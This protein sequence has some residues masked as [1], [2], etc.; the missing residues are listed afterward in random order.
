MVMRCGDA[1]D[2]AENLIY[3]L[4]SEDYKFETITGT[5]I[6]QAIVGGQIEVTNMAVTEKGLASTNGALKNYT[7]IDKMGNMVNSPKAVI[8]N[9]VENDKGLI[10]YTMYTAVG[11][12]ADVNVET[13]VDMANRG[14][15]A[16]GKIRHTSQ[17][18][19]VA[20]IGGMYPLRVIE[21]NKAKE[22]KV[23]VGIMFIGSALSGKGVIKYAG[24]TVESDSAVSA[25]KIHSKLAA[26][27]KKLIDKIATYGGGT[28]D[29]D[30][31]GIK[32]TGNAG[33]YG[34]YPVDVAFDM[35][36]KAGNKATLPM[37]K[38]IIACTDYDAGKDEA[39]VVVS[40]SMTIEKHSEGTARANKALK[41][42]TESIFDKL[43]AI[44]L[45]K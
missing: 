43:K 11:T 27:N 8:L 10:G 2:P 15:I 32:R 22:G 44:N 36:E 26:A 45:S 9:R 25:T 7:L 17:G 5:N 41:T 24:I 13:A 18:D 37:G 39:N 3:T 23:K 6:A 19:I 20:S 12:L 21:I 16:N 30:A 35:I 33:F 42:Y 29:A 40:P 34:V 4:I 14:E 28:E 38:L 31:L 1:K